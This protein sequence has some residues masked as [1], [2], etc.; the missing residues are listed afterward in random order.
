MK[1]GLGEGRPRA[2]WA[3]T[4]RA[5]AAE[6][7]GGQK[8]ARLRER[9]A[10]CQQQGRRHGRRGFEVQCRASLQLEPSSRGAD[11]YLAAKRARDL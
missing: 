9:S 1:E 11:L 2:A 6:P 8:C 7:D 3:P 4:E 5:T 10:A